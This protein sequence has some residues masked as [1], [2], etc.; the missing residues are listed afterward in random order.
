MRKFSR[1]Q[2]YLG[3]GALLTGALLCSPDASPVR[4]QPPEKRMDTTPQ[5]L[6][7]ITWDELQKQL[8]DPTLLT[9]HADE[10]P[11]DEVIEKLNAQL[12]LDQQ[13]Q[14]FPTPP[15]M[16]RLRPK[17]TA[18]YNSQRLWAVRRDILQKTGVY[19]NVASETRGRHMGWNTEKSDFSITVEPL[20]LSLQNV[21]LQSSLDLQNQATPA[22][23]RLFVSGRVSSD[24]AVRWSFP[25]S[26]LK[27]TRANDATGRSLLP[28]ERDAQRANG[29]YGSYGSSGHIN[30][31]LQPPARR[32]GTLKSLQGTLHGAVALTFERWKIDDVLNA[33]N[34]TKTIVNGN[35][36]LKLELQ[37]VEPAGE[38]Y[39]V[40]LTATQSDNNPGARLRLSTGKE[41]W[42]NSDLYQS[43][44]LVDDDNRDLIAAGISSSGTGR[45]G[46]QVQ[47]STIDF[48]TGR[49][50]PEDRTGPPAK[51]IIEYGTDWRELII[52]FEFKDIPLP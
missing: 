5:P 42:P 17:L 22:S 12:P 23:E 35:S 47:T 43:L 37:S 41:F 20:T 2:Q 25:A 31:S 48:V 6:Q 21:S 18:D 4:A 27:I 32:G 10:M 3:A 45:N 34:L 36:V 39:R 7:T 49:G 15:E 38:G 51:L 44:R 29:L 26:D 33:K 1:L 16:Q 13:I 52:P 8:G 28:L 30:I 50:L 11:I 24:P 40:S 19:L 46:E 9:L 14:L